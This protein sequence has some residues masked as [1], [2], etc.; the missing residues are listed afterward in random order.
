MTSSVLRLPAP[1]RRHRIDVEGA[2]LLMGGVGCLLLAVVWGGVEYPWGSPVILGLVGGGTVLTAGFLAWETR[3][4]EPLLPLRLFRNPIFSVSSALG[5]LIGFALFGGV[6]FLPLF[7]QVVT[8]V[9]ATA[10]GLL[11]LPADG[12]HGRRIGRLGP[13]DDG[14]RSLQGVPGRRLRPHRGRHGAAQPE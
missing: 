4:A 13:A 12:R 2:A 5:F 3:V 9:S 11:I 1:A 10:S 7:L 8:G 14:H 6:V